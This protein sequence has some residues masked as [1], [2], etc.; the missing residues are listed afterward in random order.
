MLEIRVLEYLDARGRSP[1]ATWF[2]GLNAAAAA[3]VVAALQHVRAGN[4]SNI[5]GIGRGVFE[6]K[7]D[8]GPGYRIYFGK[9]GDTVMI[10][11]ARIIHDGSS[12]NCGVA[13]RDGHAE[14]RGA[15]AY[16]KQYVDAARGEPARRHA[17]EPHA[18][19][20]PLQS[21]RAPIAFLEQ[22]VPGAQQRIR[23]CSRSVHE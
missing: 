3:K 22:W 17:A 14:P 20:D 5:K 2:D 23:N 1:F 21:R 11:L 18:G 12:R 8:S 10:L 15:E 4:W 7:I 13:K 16:L 6:R 19:R 9:D